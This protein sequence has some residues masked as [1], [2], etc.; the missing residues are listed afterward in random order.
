MMGSRTVALDVRPRSQQ[1][2]VDEVVLHRRLK[3]RPATE[4]DRVA[5]ELL[6]SVVTAAMTSRLKSEECSPGSGWDRL[7]EAT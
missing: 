3:Q 6:L 1:E 7:F 4:H 5:R 2:L